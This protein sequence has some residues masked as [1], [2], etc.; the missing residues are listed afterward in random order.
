MKRI[1]S[2]I[3]ERSNGKAEIPGSSIPSQIDDPVF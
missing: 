3:E 1:L 2:K